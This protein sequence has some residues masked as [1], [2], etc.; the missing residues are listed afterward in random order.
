MPIIEDSNIKVI[1]WS[2]RSREKYWNYFSSELCKKYGT[3]NITESKQIKDA[4]NFL[5]E[6]ITDK[7][8]KI[9][10]SQENI[11]FYKYVFH[12]N[13]NYIKLLFKSESGR[14]LQ[15]L[16]YKNFAMNRRV[17][18]LILEQG[19]DVNIKRDKIDETLKKKYQELLEDLLYIGSWAYYI[20]DFISIESMLDSPL[21]IDINKENIIDIKY[22]NE[23]VTYFY[24][25]LNSE[26]D[27]DF[28]EALHNASVERVEVYK[29]KIQDCFNIDYNFAL[30]QIDEIQKYHKPTDSHLQ[31]IE[32]GT[33]EQNLINNGVKKETAEIFYSGLYLSKNNKQSLK[34]V[35][36]RPHKLNRFHYKP[37]LIYEINGK[38]RLLTSI[39][40]ISETIVMLHLKA[41]PW[42]ELYEEWKVNDCIKNYVQEISNVTGSNLEGHI[43]QIFLNNKSFAFDKNITSLLK[44]NNQNIDI[45]K[46]CGEI[47]FVFIDDKNKII[48]VSDCK[49]LKLRTEG[50]GFKMDFTT[51]RD[52]LEKQLENKVNFANTNKNLFEEHFEVLTKT[53]RDF[54]T[55][56]VMGCF[57]I[58]TPTLYMYC[59]SKFAIY[60]INALKKILK[61][62]SPYETIKINK[63]TQSGIL[64]T[65][66]IDYP[67]LKSL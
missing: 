12:F 54:S 52:K 9:I 25:A 23:N 58:S 57:I 17:L 1:D 49:F 61:N 5:F 41:F 42:N 37:I 28:S 39:D 19:C 50:V 35:I 66:K 67:Y 45:I 64:Y 14:N 44:K 65:D 30:K 31:D 63:E 16:E 48:Y 47:D 36:I 6:I 18:G 21:Y 10:F 24:K 32:F 2:D 20:A 59:D 40:K 56:S 43:E 55:Y 29:D 4:L 62:V 27:N 13:N 46:K 38:K 15:E 51:F 26:I 34:E 8:L 60:T 11:W 3:D 53:K 22:K 33:L 7:F